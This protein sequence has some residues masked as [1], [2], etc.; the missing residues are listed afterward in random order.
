Y[1]A[2]AAH[3]TIDWCASNETSLPP[4]GGWCD[5]ATRSSVEI[6]THK[7]SK[8]GVRRKPKQ[9]ETPK[10][11]PRVLC[12]SARGARRPAFHPP[13]TH[14]HTAAGVVREQPAPFFNAVSVRPAMPTKH[15][16]IWQLS[17]WV[18]KHEPSALSPYLVS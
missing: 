5:G 4:P 1:A 3:T 17:R 10:L 18:R 13:P 15:P 16:G 8:A 14:R 6:K 11:Q 2:Q 12:P 7:A 9:E